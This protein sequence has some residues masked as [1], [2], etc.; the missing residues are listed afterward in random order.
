M[1]FRSDWLL[2]NPLEIF[3]DQQLHSASELERL[4]T[5]EGLSNSEKAFL[6]LESGQTVQK[7]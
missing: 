4:S 7:L 1:S 2:N 5:P 6:F 3:N